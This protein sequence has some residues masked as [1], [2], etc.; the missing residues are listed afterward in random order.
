MLQSFRSLP[1]VD[2]LRG[3]M[4]EQGYGV[5]AFD[6]DHLCG[7]WRASGGTGL[8]CPFATT[9]RVF[10][11]TAASE[12]ATVAF[13][14]QEEPQS[15][16]TAAPAGSTPVSCSAATFTRR[17][18]S[19]SKV[20]LDRA[21]AAAAESQQQQQS[22]TLNAAAG[23]EVITPGDQTRDVAFGLTVL[24]LVAVLVF[25]VVLVSYLIEF[26]IRPISVTGSV[27]SQAYPKLDDVMMDDEDEASPLRL[28]GGN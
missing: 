11:Y 16:V 15:L 1:A 9:R 27:V 19:P 20:P 8:N 2:T 21:L 26:I 28:G 25:F 10:G 7:T 4:R 12:A 24:V 6:V 3:H 13:L 14:C 22:R 18:S 5:V 23:I 17:A